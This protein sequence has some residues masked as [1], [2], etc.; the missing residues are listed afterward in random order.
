M[1]MYID[2]YICIYASMMYMYT[3]AHM[4]LSC[5]LWELPMQWPMELLDSQKVGELGLLVA[6]II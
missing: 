3:P 6:T 1:Y 4:H 5:V 2:M